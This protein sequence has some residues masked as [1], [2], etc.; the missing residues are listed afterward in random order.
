MRLVRARRSIGKG[1]KDNSSWAIEAGCLSVRPE[2]LN[3]MK[4]LVAGLGADE[5]HRIVDELG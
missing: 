1:R 2:L 3:A 5:V 4:P